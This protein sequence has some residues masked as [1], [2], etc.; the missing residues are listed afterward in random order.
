MAEF[1]NFI[2][3]AIHGPRRRTGSRF[4]HSQ[5]RLLG[6]QGML[7]RKISHWAEP[8][9]LFPALAVLLWIMIWGG[10]WSVLTLKRTEASHAAAVATSD[11]LDTYEAYV[12]R[13]LREIDQTLNLVRFWRARGMDR[14]VLATLKAQGLLPPDLLFTVSIA[15]RTGALIESTKPFQ[16]GNL[17]TQECFAR[18][19][20][21]DRFCV[22]HLPSGLIEDAKLPFTRRLDA[23]DGSFD[24]VV[25]VEVDATYFVSS[26][27]SSLLGTQGVLGLL[28]TDS[29]LRLRRTADVVFSGGDFDAGALLARAQTATLPS[30]ALNNWDGVSRWTA[31]RKLYGFPLALVVGL[32]VDEQLAAS[33]RQTRSYKWWACLASALVLLVTT[34]LGRLSWQLSRSRLRETEARIEHARQVE[35]LAYHDA[36]TGLPNRSLFTKLLGQTLSEAQRYG[37]RAAVA[38]LDLDRFKQIN[39]TLGHDAG[40]ELLREVANRLRSCV[41]ESDTVARLGGDEFVVLLPELA[42]E[43]YAAV[44]ARKILT[45]TAKPFKLLGQEFRV[46]ASIGIST[47]PQDG[48]DEETLKKNADI[49]MYHAKSEGKNNFQFFSRELNANS[50]ERLALESS[51]RHA[52]ERNELRLLYQAKRDIVRGVIT[53]MEALLRWEHPDLGVLTPQRFLTIAEDTSLI[54]PIGKWVLKTACAQFVAWQNEGLSISSIAVNL[55]TR[56]FR[57]EQLVSDIVAVLAE[58]GMDP[59]RLELEFHESVLIHDAEVSLQRLKELKALGV[60][61]AVD[62]FGTG[63]SSLATLQR[64]P[65]DTIKIDRSIVQ[66]CV[67][68]GENTEFAEAVI[69]MSKSL[70]LT[71]VAQ[72]V[73]SGEQVKVLRTHACDELQGFYVKHP[74]AAAE[75]ASLLREEAAGITEY[76][77]PLLVGGSS[78]S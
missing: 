6:I 66:D 51:L 53:G 47:Y 31:A 78:G 23:P 56:Q 28:G 59:R 49:A 5:G 61:V 60:R 18:Q 4:P 3:K 63:Y 71:V 52:L 38:F 14:H 25:I 58:T 19:R 10:T 24:G 72:G 55:T 12:V 46:T 41:R 76:H 43:Q 16:S 70:S 48:H 21:G 54:I 26:Y 13:S 45:A 62:D 67:G 77:S 29:G 65:L 34:V 11:L 69:A 39:D 30:I 42:D 15:D 50:L 68:T 8:Q 75:L 44:V 35:Y 64:F 27:Q 74:I 57:D 36:L 20:D 17:S 33:D 37:R 2:Q 9:L 7:Q 22:G 32:S 73:E 1:A 40:D